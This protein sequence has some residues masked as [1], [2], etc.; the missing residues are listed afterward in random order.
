MRGVALKFNRLKSTPEN[1]FPAY[2]IRFFSVVQKIPEKHGGFLPHPERG[3]VFKL[4]RGF[5]SHNTYGKV[6]VRQG[7]PKSEG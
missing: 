7:N 1:L 3:S 6:G 2:S 4:V 5:K